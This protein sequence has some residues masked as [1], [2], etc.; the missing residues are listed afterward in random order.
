[1]PADAFQQVQAHRSSTPGRMVP[2]R[3]EVGI[4]PCKPVPH[5]LS[6]RAVIFGVQNGGLL[7]ESTFEFQ[8][9][10]CG[11]KVGK[12]AGCQFGDHR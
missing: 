8:G 2:Q 4:V 5:R 12:D 11:A 7:P 3:G 10:H 1:M 6:G 9:D